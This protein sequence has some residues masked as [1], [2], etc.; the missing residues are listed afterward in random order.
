MILLEIFGLMFWN[1][2]FILGLFAA[3]GYGD[4]LEPIDTFLKNKLVPEKVVGFRG[5][6]YKGLIGCVGCMSTIWGFVFLLLICQTNSFN[7][8]VDWWFMFPLYSF[9]LSKVN[10]ILYLK[11]A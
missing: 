10:C 5:W 7:Y 3:T 2:L 4:I 8:L 1:S 11:F 6:I 9:A